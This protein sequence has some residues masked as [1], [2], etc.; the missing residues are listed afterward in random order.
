MN[1]AADKFNNVFS[2]FNALKIKVV[3]SNKDTI[4]I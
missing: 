4:N 1:L 3:L 2:S